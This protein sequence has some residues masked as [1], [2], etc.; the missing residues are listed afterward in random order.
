MYLLNILIVIIVG[1]FLKH[2]TKKTL[3]QPI[4]VGGKTVLRMNSMFKLL[5][6]TCMFLGWSMP[7]L[8]LIIE[9]YSKDGMIIMFGLLIFFLVRD[10]GYILGVKIIM[11]SMTRMK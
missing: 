3:E 11:F 10:I 6:L 1:A 7:I 4:E 5:G 8:F 9:D 2:I